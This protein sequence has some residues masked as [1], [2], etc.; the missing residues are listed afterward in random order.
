M[1][2]TF[3][4]QLKIR[5]KWLTARIRKGPLK[6]KRWII[7]SGL[8]FIRGRYETFKTR[9]FMD[10]IRPG[11]VIYDVGGHV[12]YYTVLCATLAGEDG[13]VFV[14]EPRP[15]NVAYIR[16]HL[17]INNIEN[18]ELIEA[19]VS[20]KAGN[21]RF[22]FGSGTGT[23]HLA[24]DG[25]IDVRT[26][27]L[28]DMIDGDRYPDP[29]FIKM[30]IEGGETRALNGARNV[31]GKARPRMLLATHDDETHRFVTGFLDEF[32]YRYEVLNPEH[33]KGDTEIIAWPG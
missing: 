6:G 17:Q 9:A 18:V 29:D 25:I 31:I 32:G 33:I 30:D 3:H 14:F 5:T 4:E 7:A 23:G 10:N 8:N 22:H 21:A 13:R 27:V 2:G 28:D 11:D 15:M 12:G 19:A 24:D 20:D 26:L 1:S 16:R